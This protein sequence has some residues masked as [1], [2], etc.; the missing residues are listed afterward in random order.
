MEIPRQEQLIL[1]FKNDFSTPS[2]LLEPENYEVFLASNNTWS[3]AGT[4]T[5][6]DEF[7]IYKYYPKKSTETSNNNQIVSYKSSNVTIP[8]YTYVI[9]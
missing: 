9:D 8:I 6:V 7:T 2:S 4:K 5:T 3:S 1:R